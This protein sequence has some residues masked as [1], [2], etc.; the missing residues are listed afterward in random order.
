MMLDNVV[1]V[2]LGGGGGEAK[3]RGLEILKMTSVENGQLIVKSENWTNA[4]VYCSSKLIVQ[5]ECLVYVHSLDFLK[6][7]IEQNL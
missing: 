1:G 5:N 7:F 2:G 3:V 4:Y 6:L